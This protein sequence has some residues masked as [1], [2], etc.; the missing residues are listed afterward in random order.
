MPIKVHIFFD[1]QKKRVQ[2]RSSWNLAPALQI[3]QKIPENY[4][5]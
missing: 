2:L 3:A 1:S 5:P 4:W